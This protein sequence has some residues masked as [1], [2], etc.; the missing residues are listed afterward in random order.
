M[1]TFKLIDVNLN[2]IRFTIFF[3]NIDISTKIDPDPESRMGSPF[4]MWF[5]VLKDKYNQYIAIDHATHHHN[6]ANF[7]IGKFSVFICL[8]ID[9]VVN[10][11]PEEQICLSEVS[12]NYLFS[13][14]ILFFF[15]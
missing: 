14:F 10:C 15:I 9:G 13:F 8:C 11:T 1:K 12:C 6:K 4:P 3:Q 5:N 2:L 7:T